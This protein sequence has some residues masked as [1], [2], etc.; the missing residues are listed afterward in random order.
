[1]ANTKKS[2][3]RP[4]HSG[5]EG[6]TIGEVVPVGTTWKKNANGTYTPVY[7]KKSTSKKK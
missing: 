4:A 3:D 1:M 7:P 6:K 5:Y 2:T